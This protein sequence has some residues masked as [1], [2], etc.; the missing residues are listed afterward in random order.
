[1]QLPGGM[2]TSTDVSLTVSP[3]T[4]TLKSYL[5]EN[6][7]IN[8]PEEE[9]KLAL[10]CLRYLTFECFEANLGYEGT[11]GFVKNGSYAFLDYASLHWNHHLETT[12]HTSSP[13]DLRDSSDL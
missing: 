12:L 1:M 4:D 9:T 3:K 5:V 8:G 10:L 7:R 6:K 11:L 2:Y 13:L